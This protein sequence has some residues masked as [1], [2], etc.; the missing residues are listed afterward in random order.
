MDAKTRRKETMMK[1]LCLIL[2]LVC[3][4]L[5]AKDILPKTSDSKVAKWQSFVGVEGGV[6]NIDIFT[7]F[8]LFPPMLSLP[9]F[10]SFFFVGA[11]LSFASCFPI[12]AIFS[13]F[14]RAKFGYWSFE[15]IAHSVYFNEVTFFANHTF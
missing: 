15:G 10:L 14:Y 6:G 13:K 8:N 9:R 12:S 5:S 2:C 4:G 11:T 1:R 3:W 7:A